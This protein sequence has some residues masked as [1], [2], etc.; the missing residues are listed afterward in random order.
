ME[1]RARMRLEGEH[2][3]RAVQ[4]FGARLRDSDHRPM[5]AMNAIE[6]A[7]GDDRATQCVIGRNVAHDAEAWCRHPAFDG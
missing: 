2:R 1:E 5:A 4:R 3:G 7:D 6:I